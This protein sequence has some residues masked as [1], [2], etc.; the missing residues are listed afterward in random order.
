MHAQSKV[1]LG[2]RHM[3]CLPCIDNRYWEFGNEWTLTTTIGDE[4]P[5]ILNFCLQSESSNLETIN[6][7][8]RD[9]IETFNYYLNHE[10]RFKFLG[11][12]YK[13]F[14]FEKVDE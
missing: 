5:Y 8:V 13:N 11:L 9:M 10:N 4:E 7:Q 1:G 12:D 2:I 14:T 3:N 6:H